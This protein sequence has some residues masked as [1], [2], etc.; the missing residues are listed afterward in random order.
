MT[1]ITG[2]SYPKQ[3]DPMLKHNCCLLNHELTVITH[4]FWFS[5][6][7]PF[8]ACHL[9]ASIITSWFVQK[10]EEK[11]DEKQKPLKSIDLETIS[12]SFHEGNSFLEDV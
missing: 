4:S 5:V 3:P 6:H 11:I 2:K 8:T 7:S 1:F 9:K 12:K 10:K